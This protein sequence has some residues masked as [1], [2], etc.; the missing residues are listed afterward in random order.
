MGAADDFRERLKGL[1]Y[2]ADS[3]FAAK[4]TFQQRCE[5][6][7]LA[8]VGGVKREL[9]ARAYGVNRATVR[10]IINPSSPHY[11]NVRKEFRDLGTEEFTERFGTADVIARV[12][13]Y[14]NDPEVDMKDD[15]VTDYRKDTQTVANSRAD[16]KKGD[17]KAWSRLY[18]IPL[19]L[20][21]VWLPEGR[22]IPPGPIGWYVFT[23][24]DEAKARDRVMKGDLNPEEGYGD[25]ESCRT[26]GAALAFT[27]IETSSD[28]QD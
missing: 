12:M 11:R 6:Y 26:S 25:A 5:I 22:V 2:N 7:A 10:H 19:T 17:H 3:K 1:S 21:V 20:S 15:E 18:E 23:V 4:L 13:S 16:S 28:L 27:L 9:L 14:K 24:I 8:M